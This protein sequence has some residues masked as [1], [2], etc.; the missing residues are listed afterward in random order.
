[1]WGASAQIQE[2]ACGRAARSNQRCRALTT[3]Q[4]ITANVEQPA[5]V[6]PMSKP[7]VVTIPHTL[8]RA[9]AA[10]RIRRGLG[11][12]RDHYASLMSVQEETWTND[13]VDFRLTALGQA[14]SGRI[15]VRDDDVVVTVTLPWLIARMA[16]GAQKL[17]RREGTLMLEK[18]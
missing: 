2:R 18:K 16:E 14:A 1:M 12:V 3:H 13:T 17:I 5:K 10:S 7:V 6:E 8:G 11:H 15:D 9:E 4:V